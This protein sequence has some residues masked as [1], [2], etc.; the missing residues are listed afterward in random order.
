MWGGGGG[1][2]KGKLGP[3]PSGD[4]VENYRVYMGGKLS[5]PQTASI[6]VKVLYLNYNNIPEFKS[7][8]LFKHGLC[9]FS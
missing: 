9:A 5:E 4:R 3:R 8:I 1:R 7:N 6:Y 2:S